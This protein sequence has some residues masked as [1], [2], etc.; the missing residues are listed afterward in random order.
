MNTRLLASLIEEYHRSSG[1]TEEELSFLRQTASE[2][3]EPATAVEALVDMYRRLGDAGPFG[4]EEVQRLAQAFSVQNTLSPERRQFLVETA[5]GRGMT[6]SAVVALI[7]AYVNRLGRTAIYPPEQLAELVAGIGGGDLLT[8]PTL[9]FLHERAAELKLTPAD[10]KALSD[11]EIGL[12]QP[13]RAHFPS[14]LDKLIQVRVR[15]VP[16]SEAERSFL[17]SRAERTRV[18]VEIAE[19]LIDL[20]KLRLSISADV[21]AADLI[22]RLVA[23]MTRTTG[24]G[25]RDLVFLGE[26]AEELKVPANALTVILRLER[27]IQ[28]KNL[29][30]AKL[31]LANLTQALGS[32]GQ[33][34][35]AGSAFAMRKFTEVSAAEKTVHALEVL[36]QKQ[37]E[38]EGGA[39]PL[40]AK[41]ALPVSG[42]STLSRKSV[43]AAALKP[44]LNESQVFEYDDTIQVVK[45]SALQS[46]PGGFNW[47]IHLAD[48][49]SGKA[50]IVINGQTFDAAEVHDI[51][52]SHTGD[53]IAY[54][55]RRNGTESILLRGVAVESFDVSGALTFSADGSRFAAIGRKGKGWH[56]WSDGQ[57]S[58]PRVGYREPV[59]NP[60][61][62]KLAHFVAENQRWILDYDSQ[63]GEGHMQSG[64]LVFSP[65]GTGFVYW[66]QLGK[67]YLAVSNNNLGPAF[68]GLAD[69]TFGS[70][71]RHLAYLANHQRKI[72]AVLLDEPGE[73]YDKIRRLGFSPFRQQ[74]AYIATQDQR[75]LV[76]INKKVAYSADKVSSLAWSPDG[77]I[78]AAAVQTGKEKRVVRNGAEHPA[79]E[80][81]TKLTFSPASSAM[82]YLGFRDRQWVVVQDGLESEPYMDI[83]ELSFSPDG[84]QLAF[85]G[86]IKGQGTALTINGERQRDHQLAKNLTWSGDGS[87]WAYLFF[88]KGGWFL[89]VNGHV[90][91]KLPYHEL[92]QPL[93][94]DAQ[95]GCFT[96]LVR[97]DKALLT[98]AYY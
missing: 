76:V 73:G 52:L 78:W 1:I 47:F 4:P 98:V 29:T 3:D 43:A 87:Q 15:Q 28:S 70:D 53:G 54:R 41:T 48:R 51:T 10:V 23:A 17:F 97:Q 62:H 91:N 19:A 6:E 85:L 82:G 68:E 38:R 83:D 33:L 20:Q 5:V 30:E 7:H 71:A 60:V 94:Y 50:V 26:L 45:E 57:L 24:V 74:L 18:P 69:F 64:G 86:R 65:D 42:A 22:D 16:L 81:V 80:E 55:L 63:R 25:D 40:V 37:A 49:A 11:Q 27:S 84:R 88:D 72:S 36:K 75:E 66:A 21:Y 14:L 90:A 56:L 67:G 58:P 59:F 61:N 2:L 96:L 12:H 46:H 13:E 31:L 95:R 92:L 39:K 89:N 34:P 35:V 8:E 9:K 93:R 77:E 79:F 32:E 44:G